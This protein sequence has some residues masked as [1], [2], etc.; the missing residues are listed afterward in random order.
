MTISGVVFVIDSGFMKLKAYDS[1]LGSES[2]IT[3]AISKANANQRA[4]RAGRYRSGKAFRLYTENDYLKLKDFTP[5][6]MQRC[7]LTPVVLQLKALGIDNICKF[8]F[9]SSPPSNNLIDS[10]E[11]LYALGALD[12]NSKLTTPLGYQM[13]EFP[14]HPT[15]SKALLNAENFNCTQEMLS[16]IALLQVQN[17]FTTPSG[18]KQQADKAKLKFA[19]V[20]GDHLTILNV[21]KVFKEKYTKSKTG[22][23]MRWCQENFLNFKAL[24]RATQI[25]EQ[26]TAL[27]RKFHRRVDS[28]CQDKTE[29]ILKCL[30]SAFFLNTAKLTY[31]GDYKHLRSDLTLKVHPASV[32]NLYLANTD[33]PPPKYLIYNDIVQ[34]KTYHLMR[35]LFVID[36]KWLNEL[37]ENYYEYGTAREMSDKRLKIE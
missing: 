24:Q 19:C 7:D 8:E 4:G 28:T 37:V 14:L 34:T 33:E 25:R 27:L 17:V 16:I 10:L 18:R 32:I 12:H 35:D 21:Y 26:L 2:L 29:P 13:A 30:A 1:K 6:E 3:V 36:C 15:Y 20:E 11:L 31:S 22:T 5:P 23:V 9:L